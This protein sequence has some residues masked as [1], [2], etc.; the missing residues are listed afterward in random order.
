MLVSSRPLPGVAW[1][2]GCAKATPATREEFA[3]G[4]GFHVAGRRTCFD[5]WW[6][7]GAVVT[8]QQ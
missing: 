5:V 7:T 2:G 3:V 8:E 4:I 6:W 1:R